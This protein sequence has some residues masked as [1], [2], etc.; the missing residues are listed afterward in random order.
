MSVRRFF[1]LPVLIISTFLVAP[2]YGEPK[3]EQPSI[4]HHDLSIDLR[5]DSHELIVSDLVQVN[6]PD[7]RRIIVFSLAPSLSIERVSAVISDGTADKDVMLAFDRY[8]G[9]RVAIHLPDSRSS[10]TVKW[11]YGGFVNDPPRDPRHLRFVTPSETAG[12]IG[13]EGVYLSSESRWY[14]DI[15]GSLA[16]YEVA[17]KLPPN[18]VSISQGTEGSSPGRWSVPTKSEALTL[19]ANQFVVRSREWKASNGQPIR[20]GAYLFKEDAH[21]ADEYLDAC[22]RYLDAYIPLLG[23]YPFPKFAVVENFF[24]SGLGMPSFTLL[25]AAIIKRHYTQ[26]YALGHEIVHSWIGNGVYNRHDGAN[27]VE[28][29]TTYLTNYYYHEQ[30]GDEGQAKEQRRLMLFG[31]AVYVTHDQD[32]P[33]ARFTRK[34]DEKDNAIGYQKTA[35]VF[36]MLR[37][38]MGENKFWSGLRTL[39]NERMGSYAGWSDIET[40]FTRVAGQDLQWFFDQWVE[41]SGAPRLAVTDARVRQLEPSSTGAPSFESRVT[42][43]QQNDLYR[44]PVDLELKDGNGSR[45]TER[46]LLGSAEQS[47]LIPTSFDPQTLLIDPESHLFRRLERDELPAMLNLFV[48]DPRRTI[49]LLSGESEDRAPFAGIIQRVHAQEIMK[50]EGEKTRIVASAKPILNDGG[51][52]LLLGHAPDLAP[53]DLIRESCGEKFS[54]TESGFRVA[55]HTYDG[56]TFAV[57]VSCPR[58]NRR[59]SV[60]TFL[61]GNTPEA[62]AKMARLLF[63]YGWQ[64]YVI[65]NEGAVV[66]R[67]EW[68]MATTVEVI[69]EHR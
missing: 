59:G 51:S 29:L 12:H 34:T 39:V 22:A 46:V 43:I 62:V 36:H 44:I 58:H 45:V 54:V 10:W 17:V 63:F 13:P 6:V 7:R 61:Y 38:E 41:R 68:D 66:T 31:Y 9:D 53:V 47:V 27:W 5:P 11:R 4:V 48:T 8:K 60:V 67:G 3:K 64:S 56:P 50:P 65:F 18:W 69:L 28:G 15:A 42:L 1:I 35:M 26:P 40:I 14:P 16:S 25:G 19:A 33:V 37:R 23:P 30:I 55:G 49:V 2:I 57:V 21:L 24:S 32:Y 52:I 20:L